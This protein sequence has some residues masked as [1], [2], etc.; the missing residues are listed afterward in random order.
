ML[1]LIILD[2][3]LLPTPESSGADSMV[4]AIVLWF[5]LAAELVAA[6][7]IGIGIILTLARLLSHLRQP[8]FEGYEKSRLTLA[9]FLA[10]ALEFQLAGC[11]D[12]SGLAELGPDREVGRHRGYSHGAELFAGPRNQ[13]RRE[14]DQRGRS[15]MI[16]IKEMNILQ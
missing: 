11:I 16:D 3:T 14:S 13:G 4:R 6:V 9:R 8:H 10:L 2:N 5:E 12:Y 1:L 15:Y 7:L